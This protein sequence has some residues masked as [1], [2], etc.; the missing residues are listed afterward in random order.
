MDDQDFAIYRRRLKLC[1]EQA[2][3]IPL[4]RNVAFPGPEFLKSKEII[5][6][7]L[8]YLGGFLYEF[9]N[10]LAQQHMIE[11]CVGVDN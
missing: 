3:D 2:C 9:A 11:D 7:D 4:Q 1:L 10:L 8:L 6:E 5:I